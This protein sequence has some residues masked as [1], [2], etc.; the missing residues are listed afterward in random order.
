MDFLN[1]STQGS[2]LNL[3]RWDSGS[4]SVRR[5]PR[6]RNGNPL[7][8]SCL[9]SSMDRGAWG[10]TAHGV[11]ESQRWQR[12]CV[13]THTHTH[14]HPHRL[15]RRENT[16]LFKHSKDGL[17]TFY[18]LVSQT[19]RFWHTFNKGSSWHLL[20]SFKNRNLGAGIKATHFLLPI[21]SLRVRLIFITTMHPAQSWTL[22]ALGT[23][24]GRVNKVFPGRNRGQ[25]CESYMAYNS[26]MLRSSLGFSS[27]LGPAGWK[28]QVAHLGNVIR[29]GQVPC[30]SQAWASGQSWFHPVSQFVV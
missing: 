3:Y 29:D 9:D 26:S 13:Y 17:N 5:T 8:Y 12:A 16:A 20:T 4:I 18:I 7:Q 15:C 11:R 27:K 10:P 25:V 6:A 24:L 28:L 14:T 22:Y 30:G 1:H 2:I 23:C 19:A 21:N